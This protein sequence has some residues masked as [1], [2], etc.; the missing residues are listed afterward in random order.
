MPITLPGKNVHSSVI[1]N[2]QIQD[3]ICSCLIDGTMI[4]SAM[5][6]MWIRKTLSEED[7][8]NKD[9]GIQRVEIANEILTVLFF[10][11]QVTATLNNSI[12]L[13]TRKS[14]TWKLDHDPIIQNKWCWKD[15]AVGIWRGKRN[16]NKHEETWKLRTSAHEAAW[17]GVQVSGTAFRGREGIP[18]QWT[19][20]CQ[21]RYWIYLK[22]LDQGLDQ[23]IGNLHFLINQFQFEIER[24]FKPFFSYQVNTFIGHQKV[25]TK[26]MLGTHSTGFLLL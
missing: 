25:C 15:F 11:Y 4:E 22:Q 20:S 7:Q 17:N 1:T 23:N 19:N 10:L 13:S 5:I 14:I 12:S 16:E 6:H 24:S 26:M 3:N 9:P 2:T 8:D 18:S 21:V